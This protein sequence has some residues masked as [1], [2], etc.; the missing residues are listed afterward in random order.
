MFRNISGAYGKEM[1]DLIFRQECVKPLQEIIKGI[2]VCYAAAV[3]HGKRIASPA[4][5]DR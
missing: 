5:G 2:G 4:F 3:T 1:A